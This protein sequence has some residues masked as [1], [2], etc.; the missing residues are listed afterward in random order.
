MSALAKHVHSRV[1]HGKPAPQVAINPLDFC[2]LV[3]ICPLCHEVVDI[4]APILDEVRN[5]IAAVA[6]ENGYSYI[7]DGSPGVGVLLYADDSTNVTGL[8]KAKLGL[9]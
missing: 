6:K 3:G 9:Q 7:F 5:A 8:V 4:L 2:I 1:L